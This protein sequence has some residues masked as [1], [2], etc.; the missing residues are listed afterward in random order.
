MDHPGLLYW[1]QVSD[2][3]ISKIAENITGRAKQEDNTLLVSSLNII[4]LILNSKNEG[5]MNL[6]LREVP[7]ESLIRH[8]E[9]SDERVI[10]NVL[11]LMNS[12]YNKARDHV[13]SD[14]I[15]HLHVTPFRCAIEK[16]VLRKGKQ[17]D[18]G[19]EQQLIIIQRIQ[20]NKLLEKALR[21]PTEAEIERVFQLKL[22]HGESNKGMHAN[23][24]S[25]EKRTEFLNFTEAVI[26]TPPGSLALETILS[27]VTHCADS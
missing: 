10:L 4:D 25:E 20:L 11:T 9:K 2:E 17:L 12:L 7:F 14:I 3:F 22:L 8:L 23:V 26:Q 6:V 16:S 1:S 18:V 21:I 13:K 24:M 27:F 19:I 5:K 15:E